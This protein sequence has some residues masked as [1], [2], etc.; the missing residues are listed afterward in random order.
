M[1]NNILSKFCLNQVQ[2]LMSCL[3][4]VLR[5]LDYIKRLHYSCDRVNILVYIAKLDISKF[6]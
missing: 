6:I 2:G 5:I 4:E 1:K 3:D